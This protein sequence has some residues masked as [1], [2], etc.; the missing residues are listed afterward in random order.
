SITVADD[1][2]CTATFVQVFTVSVAASGASA[3]ATVTA[4]SCTA[5]SC[6]A[7]KGSQVV[8]TAP[9]VA[10]YRFAGW[11][12]DAGCSGAGAPPARTVTAPLSCTASYVARF[13]VTG[14][15]GGGLS[16]AVTATSPDGNSTCAGPTCAADAGKA[17]TLVAPTIDGYRLVGWSGAGCS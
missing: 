2:M 11:S 12:G 4:G 1:V 7:D 6:S 9:P 16:G 10:G 15:V 5:A 8:L 14:A 3:A 13:S 17:V